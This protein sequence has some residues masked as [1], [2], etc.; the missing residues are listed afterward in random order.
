MARK[1]ILLTESN[2]KAYVDDRKSVSWVRGRRTV[3]TTKTKF[4]KRRGEY[5]AIENTSTF[6]FGGLLKIVAILLLAAS[7]FSVFTGSSNK[8]FYSLLVMLQDMPDVLPYEKLISFFS[9]EGF[10]MSLP[11]WASFAKPLLNI[12]SSIWTVVG[13]LIKGIVATWQFVFAF[14]NWLFF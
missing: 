3:S 7:L 8:T 10:I 12:I 9:L 1:R 4:N 5:Y 11:D 13:F 14:A 2:H 6:D